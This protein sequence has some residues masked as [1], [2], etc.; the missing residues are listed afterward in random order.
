MRTVFKDSAIE[1]TFRKKGFVNIP[2]LSGEEVTTL[3]QDLLA[4]QPSDAYKGNQETHIGQQSF[5]VTFFDRDVAYKQQVYDL[6][7]SKFSVIAG[8]LLNNYKC[9]QA[10]VFVKPPHS[11]FVYPHQNLTITDETKFTT[12]SFWLPLQ[13]TNLGSGFKYFQS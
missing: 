3:K 8:T 11:G 4:L 10:N 13:D 1:S 7:S 12:V 5:H 6:V 2:F 9:A